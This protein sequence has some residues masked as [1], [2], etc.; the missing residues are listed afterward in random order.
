MSNQAEGG[1]TTRSKNVPLGRIEVKELIEDALATI[2]KQIVNL[3][4]KEFIQ[5]AIQDVTE[6]LTKRITEQETKIFQLEDR[7]EKLESKL[8][9]LDRLETR[10][11]DGEQYSR[12]HCLRIHGMELPPAGTKENC[13][14]KTKKVIEK[15]N[16][17]VD[18]DAIDRAHRIGPVIER[19]EKK[20]QQIIVRLKSFKDRTSVYKNRKKATN[21]VRIRLDLTKKRLKTLLAVKDLKR[22]EIDYAFADINCNLVAKLMDGKF[23]FF[24]SVEAL[25]AELDKNK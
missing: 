19:G 9:V 6:A 14:E 18:G 1:T 25:L 11:D 16:C 12:R 13:L 8:A 17:G 20:F 3:P 23:I 5:D 4:S 2:S 10:I 21:G 7:I 15:L 24:T 22:A